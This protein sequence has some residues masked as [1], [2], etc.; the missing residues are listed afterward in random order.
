MRRSLLI[1]CLLGAVR[2]SAA[3]IDDVKAAVNRLEAKHPVRATLTI[4]QSVKSAGRFANETTARLAT[5]ELSHDAAGVS[6]TIPQALLDKASKEGRAAE[7]DRNAAEDAI[8]SIRSLSVVEALNFRDSLLALLRN[9]T[10]VEENR[11]AFRGRPARLLVL[12]LNAQPRKKSGTIQI[13]T[14]KTDDRMSL[15]IGDDNV[16]LAAERDEK[17]TAGFM[18]IRGSYSSHTSY[19]FTRANDRLVLA[20]T[21]ISEGGSGMGQKVEKRSVHALTIR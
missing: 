6:I 5:A 8:G 1:F 14:V 9:A 17:T 21:E 10:V 11:V 2:A 13:G 3:T 4:D 12:K 19:T 15:W 18:F 20:R 7:T 16:P